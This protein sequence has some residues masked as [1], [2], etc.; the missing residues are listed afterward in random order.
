LH[1]CIR[2]RVRRRGR[3]AT[4]SNARSRN[5]GT[6]GTRGPRRFS[7]RRPRAVFVCGLLL[8][9]KN[10]A[11][12]LVWSAR[13]GAVRGCSEARRGP[14]SARA[15]L[16]PQAGAPVR[17]L[18][19]RCGS[20]FLQSFSVLSAPLSIVCSLLFVSLPSSRRCSSSTFEDPCPLGSASV[21]RHR[22]RPAVDGWPS[23]ASARQS[24]ET[25]LVRPRLDRAG[26]VPAVLRDRAFGRLASSSYGISPA[27]CRRSSSRFHAGLLTLRFA[28]TSASLP[29]LF[30]L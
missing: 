7:R 14:P 30:S 6:D 4:A 13:T 24:V 20:L 27:N 21:W 8:C 16:P 11:R 10:T 1:R 9:R 23:S 12:I 19:T 5:V 26:R 2:R 17:V 29:S 25:R 15:G 22:R 3:L 28:A 18:D